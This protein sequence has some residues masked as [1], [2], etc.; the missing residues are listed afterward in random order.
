MKGEKGENLKRLKNCLL[1]MEN[2]TKTFKEM[3][4]GKEVIPAGTPGNPSDFPEI[5]SDPTFWFSDI[6]M[7]I[8][9]TNKVSLDRPTLLFA[10]PAKKLGIDTYSAAVADYCYRELKPYIDALNSEVFNR[11]KQKNETG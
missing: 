8:E 4:E 9:M 2:N 6:A 7:T 1:L 10:I 11:N 3:Y 5:A